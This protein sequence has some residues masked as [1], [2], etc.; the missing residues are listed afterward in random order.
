MPAFSRSS[1]LSRNDSA[2][3]TLSRTKPAVAQR[4]QQKGQPSGWP[5]TDN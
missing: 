2:K 1:R 4:K 3:Y 5:I